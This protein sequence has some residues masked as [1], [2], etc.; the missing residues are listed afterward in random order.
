[1][2]F[3]SRFNSPFISTG[4]ET[5]IIGADGGYEFTAGFT[6]RTTGQAGISA[7]GSNILYTQAMVNA[8][9]WMRFGFDA[10]QQAADIVTDAP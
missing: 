2:G 1:M 8:E 5:R 9:R 7:D 10:T 3:G 6:D 4:T